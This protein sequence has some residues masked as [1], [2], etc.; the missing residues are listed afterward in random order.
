MDTAGKHAHKQAP[1]W[2]F[3]LALTVFPAWFV[4]VWYLDNRHSGWHHLTAHYA[5]PG[6]RRGADLAWEATQVSTLRGT[7]RYSFGGEQ[8]RGVRKPPTETGFN[9]QGFGVRGRGIMRGPSMPVFI[10]WEQVNSCQLLRL[11]LRHGGVNLIVHDQPLLD[12]CERHTQSR[13]Y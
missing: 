4:G 11:N 5:D 13:G 8:R 10:P 12:A 3:L 9:E 6:G 1:L 2:Q 7:R